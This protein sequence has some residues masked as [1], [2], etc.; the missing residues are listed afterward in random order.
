MGLKGNLSSVSLA[1]IFQ[2]L[3]LNTSSGLLRVQAPEGPRFVELRHG[4]ISIAGRST[5][6]VMLG[7]LLISRGVI[8]DAQLDEALRMQKETGKMLGE[9][10]ISSGVVSMDQLEAALKFQIEEEVCELFT[11]KSGDFDFLE[12]AG[13]DTKIAPAGGLVKLNLDLNRLLQ[14]ASSRAEE[15]NVLQQRIP[16]QSLLFQTSADGDAMLKSGEGLSSE[17]MILLRLVKTHRTVEAMVQKACLGRFTTNRMLL[18]LSDAGIIE[19]A[20]LTIYERV[21]REHLG[22]NRHEEATRVAEFLAELGSGTQREIGGALLLEI[23]KQRRPPAPSPRTQA[24]AD[25]KVRSEVIRRHQPGLI[26]SKEQSKMP[27]IAVILMVILGA[28]VAAY[29]L[30]SGGKTGDH[31]ASRKELERVGNEANDLIL[32]EKYSDALKVMREFKSFDPEIQKQATEIFANRQKDVEMRL[33]QAIERFNAAQAER[34]PEELQ[35][36]VD[37]LEKLVDLSVADLNVEKMR[38][39]ARKE[40]QNYRERQST[41]KFQARAKAI[42]ESTKGQGHAARIAALGGLLAE[43][44]PEAIAGRLRELLTQLWISRNET[45][46]TLARAAEFRAMGDLEMARFT[47]DKVK[48]QK[49]PD[50]TAE[51]ETALAEIAEKMSGAQTRLESIQLLITQ[52]K[53][54]EAKA[55]LTKFMDEK[56]P[57]QQA[58]RALVALQGLGYDNE[59][60]LVASLKAAQALGEKAPADARKKIIELA[61]A[62]RH[63][64]TGSA[65][66]VK[67]KLSSVPAGAAV[68]V[69]GKAAGVTPVTVDAPVLGLVRLSFT[70]EGFEPLDWVRTDLRDEEIAM[71]LDRL[72]AVTALMPIAGRSGMAVMLENLVLAG[73]GEALQCFRRDLKIAARIKLNATAGKDAA[74]GLLAMSNEVFIPQAGENALLRASFVESSVTQLALDAPA[75]STPIIYETQDAT[76]VKLLAVATKS[77]FE[78]HL[79]SDGSLNNRVS[80]N[81]AAAAPM[82]L[83]FDGESFYLPRNEG[84]LVAIN[85][86][87]GLK[88]WDVN[89]G[90]EISGPPALDRATSVIALTGLNGVVTGRDV[91]TGV[92][93]WKQDL[94]APCALGTHG[95]AA[96]F[97]IFQQDGKVKLLAA[98]TGQPA[99]TAQLTGAP[100]L[101]L[102]SVNLSAGATAILACTFQADEKNPRHYLYALAPGTGVVLWRATLSGKPVAIASDSERVYVSMDDKMLMAYPLK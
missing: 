53:T 48:Q 98:E 60:A 34:K 100:S 77:G 47:Y 68:T 5:G 24:S 23:Q 99:W 70:R 6:R 35:K 22:L 94:G 26:I 37:E 44:P 55:A 12:G 101:P 7:D 52:N 51:A 1:D 78:T 39:V 87:T 64:R 31:T 28:G 79:L 45:Q 80:L 4:V 59:A 82:G 102:Q 41:G 71:S 62:N 88:K 2:T 58:I 86:M 56:P 8:D 9:V 54:A 18:E 14:E 92:E 93:K 16:S 63:S 10:L 13:L 25:P 21:A 50:Y 66:T 20:P 76:S 33:V 65:A 36:A 83:V 72:A 73:D 85:G 75:L 97:A 19:T 42:E 3:A 43:N 69:N 46:K 15:W 84:L 96:G 32:A 90:V 17:G 49:M 74:P 89:T 11:L 27:V 40:Y 29:F 91:K 95:V 38:S 81:A 61:E 57:Q 67:V 30:Y